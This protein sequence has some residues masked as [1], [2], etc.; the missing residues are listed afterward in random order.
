MHDSEK[1]LGVERSDPSD[2]GI[3]WLGNDQVVF[4]PAGLQ[5]IARI[6]EVHVQTRIAEHAAVQSFK[7]RGRF[8]D[9]G[10]NLNAV[11]TLDVGKSGHGR[12]RHTA[13]ETD[14]QNFAWMWMKHGSEIPEKQL[15]ASVQ[16]AGVNLAVDFQRNVIFRTRDGNCG[17]NA[18]PE[19]YKV[20]GLCHFPRRERRIVITAI[21][22]HSERGRR[23][24]EKCG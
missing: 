10:L 12:C 23:P 21:E 3:R 2:P 11:D 4:S 8:K 16:V 5:E 7:M 15:S 22:N 6:V 20:L 13:A 1:F 24:A 14:D 17:V 9:S 18:V 19:R